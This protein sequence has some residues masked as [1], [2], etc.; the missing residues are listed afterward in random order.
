[1]FCLE[2]AHIF[3]AGTIH[4]IGIGEFTQALL[5]EEPR[6]IA[7]TSQGDI[8]T[9]VGTFCVPCKPHH[10][11]QTAVLHQKPD[12]QQQIEDVLSPEICV[13]YAVTIKTAEAVEFQHG[14]GVLPS[15]DDF[16][17][18]DVGICHIIESENVITVIFAG[19]QKGALLIGQ[20]PFI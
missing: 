14:I 5:F 10:I 7:S 19:K 1:M 20:Q 15:Q 3:V 12:A 13:P 16:L 11:R 18:D 9:S 2:V 4:T 17:F 6:L 8:H